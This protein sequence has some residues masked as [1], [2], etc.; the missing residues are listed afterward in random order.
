MCFQMMDKSSSLRKGLLQFYPK[1]ARS[2]SE[3]DC[4]GI[5]LVSQLFN[6][7][8]LEAETG[9]EPMYTDLQSGA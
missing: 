1:K 4:W 7:A 3:S 5:V 2:E 9:I 8:M 6:Y